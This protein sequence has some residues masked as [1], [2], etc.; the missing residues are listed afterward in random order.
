MILEECFSDTGF[1]SS[2]RYGR[3]DDEA[4]ERLF[5]ALKELQ[6]QLSQER[7]VD[8]LVVSAL[9][10]LPWEMDNA[11]SGYFATKDKDQATRLERYSEVLRAAINDTFGAG[12]EKEIEKYMG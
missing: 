7:L 6:V 11:A 3:V 1:A 8:R 9:V 4:F 12:L 2:F 5:V 10:D